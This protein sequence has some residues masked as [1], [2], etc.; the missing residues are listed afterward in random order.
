MQHYTESTKGTIGMQAAL[1]MNQLEEHYYEIT[2][3]YDLAEELV[4][5]VE[6]DFVDDAEAQLKI[7]EPLI[8]EIEEAAEVLTEE[9]MLMVETP[10]PR[11]KNTKMEGAL[12]RIYVAIDA[13]HKRVEA[14]TT[15]AA[16]GFSNLADPIV[17]KIV[18]QMEA[19]VAAL[20]DL[21]DLSLDRIMSGHYAEALRQRHDKIAAML[22]NI[23]QAQGT[24]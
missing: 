10:K 17:K 9:Y 12:R 19:V 18:R 14:S 1:N 13:Y 24:S 3:L 8:E 5:T 6:S 11:Q 4:A 20:I 15:K 2:D 16:S 23:G 7:V 22:H 21:V